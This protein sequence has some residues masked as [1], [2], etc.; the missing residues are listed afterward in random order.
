MA[1]WIYERLALD[2]ARRVW[3]NPCTMNFESARRLI[4]K[5][6]GILEVE[7]E[8]HCEVNRGSD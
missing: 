8:G 2:V 5:Y 6:G 4:K 1:P 7:K 3:Y